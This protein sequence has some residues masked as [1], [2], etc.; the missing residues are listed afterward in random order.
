[1][2]V[3]QIFSMQGS[4][5]LRVAEVALVRSCAAVRCD[6]RDAQSQPLPDCGDDIVANNFRQR[7]APVTFWPS[8][9]LVAVL[10]TS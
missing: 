10:T 6:I 7:G 8:R 1:M 3:A 2:A 4:E 5:S 9:I